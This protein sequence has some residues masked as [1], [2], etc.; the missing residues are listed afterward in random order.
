M[1]RRE[2][3]TR[4]EPGR[5]QRAGGRVEEDGPPSPPRVARCPALGAS[6]RDG[7]GEPQL[8][9]PRTSPLP[10]PLLALQDQ[11]PP[12]TDTRVHKG[13]PPPS[14]VVQKLFFLKLGSFF[15]FFF[16]PSVRKM[17]GA[18]PR[19]A[20]QPRTHGSATPSL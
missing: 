16:F 5:L 15:D 1:K 17:E 7:L 8:L 2:G 19:M 20:L 4:G 11:L 18:S 14:L 3:E 12:K 9:K 13:P 10:R 6:A